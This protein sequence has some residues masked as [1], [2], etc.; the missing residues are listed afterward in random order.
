MISL[1]EATQTALSRSKDAA[2]VLLD[3][4]F[5]FD[6]HYMPVGAAK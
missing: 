5:Q 6:N 4:E 3:L 1:L 2:L